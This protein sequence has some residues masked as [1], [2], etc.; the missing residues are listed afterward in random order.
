[1]GLKSLNH[2]VSNYIYDYIVYL[3]MLALF[4][5]VGLALKT[6]IFFA[7]SP[8]KY[9]S[10]AFSHLMDTRLYWIPLFLVWGNSQ[11]AIAYFWSSIFQ[12]TTKASGF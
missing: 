8:Y 3:V 7:S 11:I 1:M 4:C 6:V 9:V 2:W 10:D 5:I 12:G